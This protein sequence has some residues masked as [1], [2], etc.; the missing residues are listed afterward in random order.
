MGLPCPR[1]DPEAMTLTDDE[2]T[3]PTADLAG[4]ADPHRRPITDINAWFDGLR[5]VCVRRCARSVSYMVQGLHLIGCY[6]RCAR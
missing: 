3:E 4:A 1:N 5:A 6:W 2:C